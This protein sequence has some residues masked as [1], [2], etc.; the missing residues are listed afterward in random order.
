MGRRDGYE[1]LVVQGPTLKGVG[2]AWEAG[3]FRFKF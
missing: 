2:D 3:L 1:H